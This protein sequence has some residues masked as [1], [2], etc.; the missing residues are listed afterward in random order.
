MTATTDIKDIFFY[1]VL[2]KVRFPSHA[3]MLTVEQLCDL[4]LLDTSKGGAPKANLDDTA[5][6]INTELKG[7]AEESFVRTGKSPKEAK[8]RVALEVVKYVIAY[9][10]ELDKKKADRAARVEDRAV[11]LEALNNRK[12]ADIDAL[13]MEELL[14]RL[15]TLEEGD[16]GE[17]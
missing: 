12:K 15:A 11:L 2:H 5:K 8:L 4:P 6:A 14:K 3:G 13:P 7:Y 16:D 17:Q 9:K 1:T 10:Q